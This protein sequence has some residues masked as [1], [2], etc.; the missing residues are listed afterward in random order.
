M[1][2]QNYILALITLPALLISQPL[3]AVPLNPLV[4]SALCDNPIIPVGSLGT[5]LSGHDTAKELTP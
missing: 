2:P 3:L 4:S 5:L 1:R